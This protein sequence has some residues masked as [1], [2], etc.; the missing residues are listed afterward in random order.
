M[1]SVEFLEEISQK[2]YCIGEEIFRNNHTYIINK[3]DFCRTPTKTGK[4]SYKKNE[5]S[6]CSRWCEGRNKSDTDSPKN[7]DVGSLGK[8][9]ERAKTWKRDNEQCQS[10][11]KPKGILERKPEVIKIDKDQ[12]FIKN[13]LVSVCIECKRKFQYK[14]KKLKLFKN[15]DTTIETDMYIC[16]HKNCPEDDP[17]SWFEMER[18][19]HVHHKLSHGE[20]LVKEEAECVNCKTSFK[21]Y[22]SDKKGKY[23]K[24]C[25][26]DEDV[27]WSPGGKMNRITVDCKNCGKAKK[28]QLYTYK[29]YDNHFCNSDCISEWRRGENHHQYLGQDNDYGQSWC[30]IRR[31]RREKDNY[32]CQRC[33][34]TKEEIGRNPDVHHIIP[35]REFDN[36]E[37]AHYIDNLVSLCRSCHRLVEEG[38]VEVP[39]N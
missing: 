9:I 16:P 37:D 19:M 21:Y 33:G 30:R 22:P 15:T 36:P 11:G 28:V 12:K 35:V 26:Q 2:N 25:V 5:K 14:P 7:K 8:H 31:K 38:N 24:E 4:K 1:S 23:C 17:E 3:C 20:S 13:N 27:I 18:G 32:T 10:C 29:R 6:F 34:E 39:D